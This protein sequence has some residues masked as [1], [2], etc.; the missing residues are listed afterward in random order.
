MRP[1]SRALVPA[2]LLLACASAASAVSTKGF[3]WF[4][5]GVQGPVTDKGHEKWFDLSHHAIDVDADDVCS[6]VV[7]TML[8]DATPWMLVHQGDV[9]AEVKID[10]VDAKGQAY[11]RAVLTDVRLDKLVSSSGYGSEYGRVEM[12]PDAID[13][14]VSKQGPDGMLEPPAHASLNCAGR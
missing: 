13:L 9:L 5:P 3:V 2:A 6:A 10:L 14:R 4:G 12:S 8:K 11:Y 1:T 7:D